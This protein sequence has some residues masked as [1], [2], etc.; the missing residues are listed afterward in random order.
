MGKRWEHSYAAAPMP[1]R[2]PF[3]SG[4]CGHVTAAF[5]RDVYQHVYPEIAAEAAET[6]ASIVPRNAKTMHHAERD[7]YTLRPPTGKTDTYKG[8]YICVIADQS[9]WG[10]RDSNPRPTGYES[11]ALTG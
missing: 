10:G 2:A 11:V 7:A 9:W 4:E 3:I 5:T 6:V 8:W 1:T